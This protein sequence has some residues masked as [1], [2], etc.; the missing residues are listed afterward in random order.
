MVG[1]WLRPL[2]FGKKGSGSMLMKVHRI[3]AV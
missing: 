1:C 3:H 2:G